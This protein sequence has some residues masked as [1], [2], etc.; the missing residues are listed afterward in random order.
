MRDY[1]KTVKKKIRD[2]IIANFDASGYDP[3]RFFI[4]SDTSIFEDVA[5]SILQI[6]KAEE[7]HYFKNPVLKNR[8]SEFDIFFE[9]CS[10]LPSV[11]D[12]C[13]FYNRSA[14]E[15]V[16]ELLEEPETIAKKYN[17]QAAERYLTTLIYRE[18][19]DA[20]KKGGF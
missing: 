14:V 6:F 19:K 7:I 16:A 10:G 4:P 2:Y 13:Y 11:L 8:Y 17:E 5:K 18:L 3:E 1:H 9:W 15:D 20:T 12:T